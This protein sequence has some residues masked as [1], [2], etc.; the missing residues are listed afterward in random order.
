MKG[1]LGTGT[2]TRMNGMAA[3]TVAAVL[4]AAGTVAAC[5]GTTAQA[6]VGAT[7]EQFGSTPTMTQS[8][9][10]GV[11]DELAIALCS[12]PSTGYAWEQPEVAD[13]AV[14][15]VVDSAYHA[16]GATLPVVGAAGGQ[17]MTIRGLTTGETTV[18]VRYSRPWAGG[19]KGSWTYTLKVVVQ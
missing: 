11:G 14:I 15:K 4:L 5:Q 7:C 19:E 8:A 17:V 9:Q 18:L 10:L 2:T 1:R 12:N 16:P 3:R 13:P 6:Q